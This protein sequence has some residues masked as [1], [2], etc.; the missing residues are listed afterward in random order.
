MPDVQSVAQELRLRAEGSATR[1]ELEAE[2][3]GDRVLSL[4]GVERAL[5][6]VYAWALVRVGARAPEGGGEQGGPRQ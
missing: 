1:E 4:S 2:L 6:E 3:R 5:L